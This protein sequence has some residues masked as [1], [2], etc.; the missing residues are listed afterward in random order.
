MLNGLLISWGLLL[1]VSILFLKIECIEK[2]W[3][4]E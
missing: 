3:E 2:K 1:F 4:K